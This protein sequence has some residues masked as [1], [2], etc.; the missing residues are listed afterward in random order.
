MMSR[1]YNLT[2]ARGLCTAYAMTHERCINMRKR[3]S[4]PN[5]IALHELTDCMMI[6][7][8]SNRKHPKENSPTN[9]AK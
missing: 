1:F 4:N 9:G 2:C 5:D 3:F 7:F 6:A 8:Y